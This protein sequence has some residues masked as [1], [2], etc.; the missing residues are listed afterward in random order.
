LANP[1]SPTRYQRQLGLKLSETNLA[2]V[3]TD[4]FKLVHFNGGLPPLLFQLDDDPGELVNV[5]VDPAY[6]QT[7]Q[8]LMALMLD[9]RMSHADQTLTRSALTPD[10]VKTADPG[11]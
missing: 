6:S 10:G 8:S 11:S 3:R 9:H 1:V 5:A 2:L 7:L 4:R